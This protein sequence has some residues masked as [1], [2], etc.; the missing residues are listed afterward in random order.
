MRGFSSKAGIAALAMAASLLPGAQAG[1]QTQ[2]A[3]E[4]VVTARRTGIPVWRVTGPKT[5]LVLIGS[6]DGVAKDTKWDPG[7]LTET[8]VKADRVMFPGMTQ[9]TGSP[10]A[11]LG[12]YMKFKRQAQLPKGQSLAQ[13][14]PAAEFQRLVALKN[15]GVLKPGFERRHPLHLADDLRDLARGKK[16]YGVDADQYVLRAVRKHKIK[17]VPLRSMTAKPLLQEFFKIPPQRFVPCLLGA[18]ALAE[19]GPGTV[20][21]R[22][23]A[24]AE[25]RVPEVLASPADKVH[26][27]CSPRSF[28]MLQGPDLS[29]EM[30]QL[31][32]DP[33]LTVAVLDL[34]A[35]ATTGGVLDDLA[36]A[37]FQ[38]QGPRW[39]R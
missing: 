12:Y 34:R 27:S 4:I 30:R 39:R 20:K 15:R 28:G 16:G 8:L 17:T 29:L 26:A 21:A 24:W 11:L 36:A 33:R 19:A 7:A 2:Q 31:M 22:S 37:G 1:A 13:M 14:M 35:L 23:D 9:L 18:V 38:I 6:I 25:R 5:T 10:L 32:A 3:D